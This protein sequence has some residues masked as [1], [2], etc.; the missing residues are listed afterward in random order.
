MTKM[1]P[2]ISLSL[3][4]ATSAQAV[5]VDHNAS[6]GVVARLYV[7]GNAYFFVS[8]GRVFII[9]HAA[10]TGGWEEVAIDW[11]VPFQEVAE[12]EAYFMTTIDG[13]VWGHSFNFWNGGEWVLLPSLPEGAVSN[14]AAGLDNV[15][16]MFR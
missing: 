12:I 15:K 11:P 13:A 14:N 5:P 9:D 10:P 16:G 2:L 1:I 4:L 3:L 8:D 6:D 7:G